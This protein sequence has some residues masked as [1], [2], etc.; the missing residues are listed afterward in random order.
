MKPSEGLDDRYKP[1]LARRVRRE[2]IIL[3]RAY[4]IHARNGGVGVAVEQ[5]GV[6]G[7][8]LHREKFGNHF[9]FVELDWDEDP[10][11]GTAIPLELIDARPPS[12]DDELLAW[13]ASQED[14]HRT[15]IEA[16]WEVILGFSPGGRR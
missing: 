11:F 2:D 3:G 16:A 6:I 8:R 14:V 4:L 7:F 10:Q 1:L 5:D 12:G 15:E 9:L 13:L